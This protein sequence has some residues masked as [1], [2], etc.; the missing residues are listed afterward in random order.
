MVKFTVTIF[1]V[2]FPSLRTTPW[3]SGGIT[4]HILSFGTG[5]MS[6]VD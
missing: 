6:V 2:T 1:F 4:P 5:W 3:G